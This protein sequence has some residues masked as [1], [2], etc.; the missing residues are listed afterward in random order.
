MVQYGRGQK[1]GYHKEICLN[2]NGRDFVIGDIH[3]NKKRLLNALDNV[4]FN[5]SIDRLFAV[6][7][8]IDGG[9]DNVKVLDMLYQ[10]EWFY[11]IRGNHEQLLI[12]RYDFPGDIP[13]CTPS[14]AV[15]KTKWDAAELHRYNGGKW[16]DRLWNDNAK[17]RIYTLL[18]KL[19]LA[20]TIETERGDV[21][22]VHAGVPLEFKAWSDFLESL[23]QDEMVR[24]EALWTRD[25]IAEFYDYHRHRKWEAEVPVENR[26]L[27]GI[28]VTVHGHTG[29]GAKPAVHCNSVFI[30]A[31]AGSQNYHILEVGEL[32]KLVE[33]NINA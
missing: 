10:K 30:D 20:M 5:E 2:E 8:L 9:K 32:F 12:N 15:K 16:F 7:D 4:T 1:Q 31:G 19:P 29:V 33:E 14:E 11:S 26:W 28:G 13:C 24:E 27:D 22:L 23:E 17:H 3:A 6:G 21:G 25:V 18:K